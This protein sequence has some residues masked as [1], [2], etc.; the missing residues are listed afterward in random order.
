M[1]LIE[2]YI[3][4]ILHC[5]FNEELLEQ[6]AYEKQCDSVEDFLGIKYPPHIKNRRASDYYKSD[7][8]KE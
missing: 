1:G 3:Q 5:A 6:E 2:T 4:E 7:C 8:S